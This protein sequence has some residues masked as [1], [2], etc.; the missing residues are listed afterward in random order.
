M[1]RFILFITLINNIYASSKYESKNTC[2]VCHPNIYNE[3]YSSSHRK[4]SIY[5]D[6]IHKA[7]WNLHPNNKKEKYTCN[8]CHT[9]SDTRVSNALKNNQSA[10]PKKDNIQQNEAVSC[11][12][13]HNISD[14][15][16]HTSPYDE[17]ILSN[18]TKT[19]YS[20][21]K[22]LRDKK[23]KYK[24]EKSFFG[25]MKKTKGSPYHD[26]DYTNDNFYTGKMCMACHSHFENKIGINVCSIDYSGANNEEKNCIT[27]HMPE[28]K[29]SVTTIKITKTHKYHGFPGAR[30]KPKMLAKYININLKRTK[31]GFDLI[32]HNKASHNFLTHPLRLAILK[33]KI[34]S[35][36]KVIQLKDKKFLRVLAKDSKPAMP[37]LANMILKDNMLKKE[38][39]RVIKYNAKIK[40]KDII[41]VE[42]GF[43]LV[44]PK[45][46]KKLKLQNSKEATKYN[47][48]KKENFIIK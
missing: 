7:I 1:L 32:L 14:I 44:N 28:V 2:K 12:Y 6:E 4:A 39:K 25:L 21:N 10:I 45:L 19:F 35:N 8:Q 5:E 48:I 29:G 34:I 38:E 37:W 18:K 40:S 47:I 23:I 24:D 46:I 41:Y 15:K 33:V 9:P 27:C 20:A 13:C 26:I 31:N 16:K 17:N 43:Y 42:F 22:D 30:H 3:F 11:K 36:K